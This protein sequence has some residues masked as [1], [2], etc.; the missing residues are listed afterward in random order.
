VIIT[1]QPTVGTA[2]RRSRRSRTAAA[3]ALADYVER[4][5]DEAPPLTVTERDNLA[6]L[7]RNRSRRAH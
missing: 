5:V 3:V 1:S 6:L 7:L 2:T 4:V